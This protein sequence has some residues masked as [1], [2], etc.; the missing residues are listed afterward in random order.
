MEPSDYP[1]RYILKSATHETK[2]TD[3]MTTATITSSRPDRW[4]NPRPW[5]DATMRQIK[6]GRIR[7]MEEP[8]LL[9]R[10]F[11]RH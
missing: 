3:G 9:A 2:E 7:P 6:H 4:S 8:G 5:S 1:V 10:W 11:G